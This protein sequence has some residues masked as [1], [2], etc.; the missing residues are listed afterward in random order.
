MREYYKNN[1]KSI[2][3]K[4]ITTTKIITTTTK[5]KTTTIDKIRSTR[6]QEGPF[7][8]CVAVVVLASV[9]SFT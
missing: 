3:T 7:L 8:S 9:F 2:T 1:N 6:I 5:E 4:K